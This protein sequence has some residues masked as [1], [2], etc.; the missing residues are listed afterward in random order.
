MDNRKIF[1]YVDNNSHS[2]FV[3]EVRKFNKNE[4]GWKAAFIWKNGEQHP[5]IIKLMIPRSAMRTCYRDKISEKYAKH[6]CDHAKVLG[7][8][9]YYSGRELKNIEH[10]KSF[11]DHAMRYRKGLMVWPINN[12]FSK[13]L[14]VCDRGIHYFY[15]KKSALI[16][17]DSVS[18]FYR[19]KPRYNHIAYDDV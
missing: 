15:S 4:I 7:F 14:F 16:Y 3:D 2:Q 6:R 1:P 11:Y 17:M 12:I 10:A 18:S 19:V 13:Q 8:Y 5:V 9:S